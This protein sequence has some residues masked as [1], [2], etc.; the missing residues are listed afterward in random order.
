MFES[1]QLFLCDVLQMMWWFLHPQLAMQQR[2]SLTAPRTKKH[3]PSRGT[4]G[5]RPWQVIS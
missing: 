2:R 4:T 5:S 1:T 3:P